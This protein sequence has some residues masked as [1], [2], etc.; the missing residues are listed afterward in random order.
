MTHD[1]EFWWNWGV[2]AAVALGTI[3]AVL[4]A[5]FGKHFFFR[6]KLTLELVS[7][8]GEPTTLNETNEPVRYFHVR[9]KNERRGLTVAQQVQVYLTRVEEVGPTGHLQ[10]VWE[11]GVP[12]R[13]RNQEIVPMLRS[14]G[15]AVD[16]DLFMIGKESGL[17]LMTLIQ[18]NSLRTLAHRHGQCRF[19]VALQARSTDSDSK[20][21]RY[22][23]AWDGEWVR[24]AHPKNQSCAFPAGSTCSYQRSLSEEFQPR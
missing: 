14:I 17:H 18:P 15:P 9:V 4:V 3:S 23:I 5:L 8:F 12:M 24:C 13:W 22:E 2:N 20:I 7:E 19:A 1:A 11:E 6:P 16:A 21:I 10:I